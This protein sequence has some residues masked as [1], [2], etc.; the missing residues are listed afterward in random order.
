MAAAAYGRDF[1][2]QR[3]HYAERGARAAVAVGLELRAT[4]AGHREQRRVVH[5]SQT[6]L[7]ASAAARCGNTRQRGAEVVHMLALFIERPAASAARRSPS[8]H[9]EQA[10]SASK[11]LKPPQLR[12]EPFPLAVQADH[13]G[14][15]GK[16]SSASL[17]AAMPMTPWCQPSAAEDEGP[18]GARRSA[19]ARLLVYAVLYLLAARG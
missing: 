3:V 9:W 2:E 8:S 19:V 17:E 1:V 13:D 10:E 14:R 7:D 4:H 12:Q 11:R 5:A 15:Q 16:N 6:R 18:W